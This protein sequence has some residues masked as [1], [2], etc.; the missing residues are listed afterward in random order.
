VV[1]I[2]SKFDL[3]NIFVIL[4]C[5]LLISALF[6]GVFLVRAEAQNTIHVGTEAE[7]NSA[8]SDTETDTPVIIVLDRTIALTSVLVIP[9][10]KEITLTSDAAFELFGVYG[11]STIT[12][13]N[14]GTLTLAGITVTH[15]SGAGGAG[16]TVNSGGTLFMSGG[17]ISGNSGNGVSNSGEFTMSG[18]MISNNNVGIHVNR[19]SKVTFLG[20]EISNNGYGV[21]NSG[22]FLMSSGKIASNTG[23]GVTNNGVFIMTGGEISNN[24]A[25]YNGGGVS[26]SG[27]FNMTQG[28]VSNNKAPS[29][30]GVYINGGSFN[31]SGGEI[32]GNNAANGGG[33]YIN[34]G[35]FELYG[36]KISDNTASTSGGGVW[37]AAQNLGRLF[38]YDGVV[39][40]NNRASDA[41]TRDPSHDATYN[42]YI[43]NN[44]V[45]TS[46]FTQGYNNYD[47]SYTI[48]MPD[49]SMKTYMVQFAN[50]D[51][52][53]LKTQTVSHGGSASPPENPVAEGYV[54]M[55]WD[56]EFTNVTKDIKVTALFKPIDA[57]EDST[58]P[59]VP[60]V[61]PSKQSDIGGGW[62][63]NID[64]YNLK[65]IVAICVGPVVT[66]Y[67][68][69]SGL[70][71][72]LVDSWL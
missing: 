27:V 57:T 9:A 59:A 24:N 55:G 50:W 21:S 46:P 56:G 34:N 20:G 10:N 7:L 29:G 18:G 28:R 26:N 3:R 12:V 13:E 6:I 11:A 47:I 32:S 65:D 14:R 60:D 62:P 45:W 67:F 72:E 71:M 66:F 53:I 48:G 41:Y 44:V 35:L 68:W 17:K 69:I 1:D 16:V 36:G 2:K 43:G 38:V 37:V 54:F 4:S 63:F 33:V 40:S 31:M 42:A 8:I 25:T 58:T 15:V 30:G 22:D 49:L 61:T 64:D 19:Y 23:G 39:F 70:I 52:T 5:V 51:G